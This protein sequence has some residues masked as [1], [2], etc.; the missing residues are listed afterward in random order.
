MYKGHILRGNKMTFEQYKQ[1]IKDNREIILNL[2]PEQAP[3]LYKFLHQ[4]SGA[5]MQ[6]LL[7]LLDMAENTDNQEGRR[8]GY[9][10]YCPLVKLE[11]E[12]AH[13]ARSKKTWGTTVVMLTCVGLIDRDIPTQDTAQ[14]P[15]QWRAVRHAAATGHDRS[16]EFISVPAY[17]PKQVEY[18][19][20][21]AVAWFTSGAT[22]HSFSKSTAIDAFGYGTACRVYQD[23]RGKTQ[24][25]RDTENA[26]HDA[27]VSLLDTHPYT[28]KGEVLAAATAAGASKA[29]ATWQRVGRV[30]LQRAGAKQHPPTLQQREQFALSGNGWIITKEVKE[31]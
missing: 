26:L 3:A 7:F 11:N 2:Q 10:M 16:M 4:R 28:T 15:Y 12:G 19:N 29:G 8:Y 22:R 27:V 13:V 14:S 23:E 21:K 17:M 25:T 24:E 9:W 18:M 31:G 1:R 30:I 6:R 20:N 5:M